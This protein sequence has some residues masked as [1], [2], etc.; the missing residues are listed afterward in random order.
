M[1][2]DIAKKSKK[3]VMLT[4]A[5][6]TLILFALSSFLVKPLYIAAS[7][8]VVYID[9]VIVPILEILIN[10]VDNL[11][12]AICFAGI[13]YSIFSFTL[14]KSFGLI[15][16]SFGIFFFKYLSA[17]I[18]DSFSYGYIDTQIILLNLLYLAIDTLKLLLVVFLSTIV[19]KRYYKSKA[20]RECA[21]VKELIGK[22]EG[23][24]NKRT[25]L[26]FSNPLHS[27]AFISAIVILSTEIISETRYYI[28][29]GF[30]KS[31]S[32][33]MWM[34]TDYL[35]DIILAAVIYSVSLLIFNHFYKKDV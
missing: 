1:N 20:D 26:S 11:A 22:N 19:I 3:R 25:I 35:T 16:V 33:A 10:I 6:S 29:M 21:H 30:F 27:S 17:F 12:Y 15:A 7:S 8:D 13:I 24:F 9:T 32:Y 5:L 31:F 34:M 18:L 28:V 4:S 14:K 23:L 2:T